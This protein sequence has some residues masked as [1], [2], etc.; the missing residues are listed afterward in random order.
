MLWL[1]CLDWWVC[2]WME[3]G[4]EMAVSGSSSTSSALS[5]A[6]ASISG[7]VSGVQTDEIIQKMIEVQSRPI[8]NLQSQ[9]ALL[10]AKLTAWQDANTRLLAIKTAALALLNP[11]TFQSRKAVSSNSDL[12]AA[13]A[14][15]GASV[16]SY[17]FRVTS[18]ASAHQMASQAFSDTNAT[19][20]GTG[21]ITIQVGS[22]P[23]TVVSITDA[24][25]TLAGVRDAINQANAG[26]QAIIINEGPANNPS[27]RLMLVSNT[28]GTA[29]AITVN[30]NLSG[31]AGLTLST[32]QA[33]TDAVL[34]FGEGSGALTVTKSSNTISDVIPGVTLTLKKADPNTPVTVD[35]RGDTEAPKSAV[36]T[37]VDAVN[38]F[39]KF[40]KEQFRY[41][42]E[43]NETGTL[44]G[45]YALAGIQSDLMSRLSDVVVGASKEAMALSQIGITLSATGELVVNDAMLE[46]ALSNNSEAVAKLLGVVGTTT[47]DGV[48][49]L[50]AGSAKASSVGYAVN[51]TQVATRARV[52]AGAAMGDTLSVDETLFV[53]GSEIKLKAGMTREQ[54]VAAINAMSGTTGVTASLTDA[55][56]EGSGNY[57][58]L[59]TTRY[60]SA[61]S[62]S[63][64]SNVAASGGGTGFGV[65]TVTQL[66][67]AGE[68]GNGTGAPG[69]DVQ[70]TINGEPATGSGQVL[71]GNSSNPNTAGLSVLVT[72]TTA[73]EHGVVRI[74]RGIAD[75]V[76]RLLAFVINEKSGPVQT[77]QE[78]LNTQIE[79]VK[80]NIEEMQKRVDANVEALRKKFID[81]EAALGKLQS[82]SAYLSAQIAA[83]NNAKK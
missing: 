59:T 42:P 32:V 12:V 41:D 35:V 30:A 54:V 67:P 50:S 25:N 56:G 15:A 48:T 5:S 14:T 31:G 37:F 8:N 7:I 62:V 18:L 47:D 64:V 29:G 21:T 6:F 26:V 79:D 34:Q 2:L 19:S 63:V 9:Q 70:G 81:M 69:Q 24:N 49:F 39:N 33:A 58:T 71:T 44:F 80:R 76:D 68:T 65:V 72:S 43:T 13:Q 11:F 57:L 16:G 40:V 45:D 53:N 78:S 83:W 77:A 61:A 74:T 52:T 22:G 4:K 55:N 20:V 82:Q 27:Y 38:S 23:A 46:D 51:I 17:T 3:R 75:A 66:N 28:T 73:G 10:T 36:K 60:G 1:L